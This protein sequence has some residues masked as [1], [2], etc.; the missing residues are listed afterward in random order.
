MKI[1]LAKLMQSKEAIARL[2]GQPLR[3]KDSFTVIRALR[4]FNREWKAFHEARGSVLERLG[5]P[6]EGSSNFE[7][8]G[9]GAAQFDSEMV[10]LLK[11]EIGTSL[12]KINLVDIIGCDPPVIMS[13]EDIYD[14]EWLIDI[15]EPEEKPGDPEPEDDQEDTETAV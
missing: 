13:A 7:L 6:V 3:A 5:K 14:L 4:M 15:P 11:V 2:K 9:E 10:D 8:E 1:T 12:A